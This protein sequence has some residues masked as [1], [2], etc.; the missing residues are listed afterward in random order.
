MNFLR[1]AA[2]AETGELI[3]LVDIK[4]MIAVERDGRTRMIA[5]MRSGEEI[6]LS[7]GYSLESLTRALDPVRNGGSR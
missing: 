2:E 7:R 4:R 1:T 6:E 5:V 3:A